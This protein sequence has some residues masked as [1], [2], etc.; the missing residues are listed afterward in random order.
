MKHL[1]ISLPLLFIPISVFA[2]NATGTH[3]TSTPPSSVFVICSQKAIDVR[4]DTVASARTAYN[5]EMDRLMLLRKDAEK[6]ILLI[7]NENEKKVAI[8]DAVDSYR[9]SV[10]KAQDILKDAR[11]NAW[12][13]FDIAVEKCR[14]EKK[15]AKVQGKTLQEKR[16]DAPSKESKEENEKEQRG[17]FDTMRAK[18]NSLKGHN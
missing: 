3:A 10:K 6:N 18:M 13:A 1:F 4:E 16:V 17:F 8:K 14:T 2:E 9:S 11:K 7:E 12:E 15:V 5:K